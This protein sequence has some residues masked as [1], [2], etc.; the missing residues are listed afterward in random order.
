MAN[1]NITGSTTGNALQ[2]L[3]MAEDVQPGDDPSYQLC[4][5]IYVYHPMGAKMVEAPITIAMSKKREIYIPN[6]PE[7]LI[8]DA[9]E[10]EW[11]KLGCDKH[12]ANVMHLKRIYGIAAIAYGAKDFPTDRPMQP[13]QLANVELYFNAFDPLNTAG[14]LV[15]NQDPNSPDFQKTHSISVQGKAYHRSRTCIVLNESPVYIAYTNSAFGYVG[16]SVFQRAL[17]PLKSYIQ[18]MITNDLVIR[19]AGVLI[20]KMKQP[21]SIVDNLTKKFMG[22]KRDLIAEAEQGNVISVGETEDVQ[23]LNLNNTDTAIGTARTNI[24]EDIA[25]SANMPPKL[26][27]ANGYASILANGTEDFKS[28]MQYIDSIRE[29]MEPLYEFFDRI[30]QLRAWNPEFYATIQAQFPEYAGI[31]YTQALYKWKNDFTAKWPSLQE[32]PESDKA[33]AE[34]VKLDAI[35]SIYE[36]L[37][38][39][40]DPENKA[41]LT[42]WVMDNVNSM[43]TMFTDPLNLDIEALMNYEPPQPEMGG[44]EGGEN[45]KAE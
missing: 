7:T 28:T 21:G 10:R 29:E 19:K 31:G 34:K 40:L 9:F 25:S 11:K 45:D 13:D 43:K 44:E 33:D 36:K 23:T 3:L 18:S 38:A 26:L 17:F 35:V 5:I 39:N 2:Q 37:S 30:V 1:V 42:E 27:L 32:E 12:I 16:R 20:A 4:K 14:S 6:S 24:I 41:K 15:L 8:K 22:Q